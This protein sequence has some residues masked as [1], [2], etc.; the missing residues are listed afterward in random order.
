MDTRANGPSVRGA[1]INF[2]SLS[3]GGVRGKVRAN[4][5][6]NQLSFE[7]RHGHALDIK[8]NAI[9][10]VHQHHTTLIPGWL[11][12]V[13]AILIWIAWRGVTGK[14]Q[15]LLGAIGIVLLASHYIT[16]KPTLTIDTK[17]DDC[18]TVFGSDL[19]MMRLCSL[20]QNI[21]NGMTL[22]EARNYVDN[23]V[24]DSDYPRNRALEVIEFEPVPTELTASP[25]ITHF[26]ESM[27]STEENTV[28]DAEIIS[29]AEVI[30]DLDIDVWNE[31]EVG[32]EISPGLINRAKDNLFTQRNQVMQNGWQQSQ[33]QQPYNEIYRSGYNNP[34][35]NNQPPV[36]HQPQVNIPAP[37]P[38][39]SEFLPSFVG[40][41]TAH[42]PSASPEMFN[43]PD[44]PLEAPVLEDD[45]PSLVASVRKENN[46]EIIPAQEYVESQ[47]DRFPE[48]SRLT[49]SKTKRRLVT[50]P[51]RKRQLKARSVVGE[52]LGPALRKPGKLLRRRRNRTTD[53][54]RIQAEHA[55]SSQITESIENLARSN[56]G[57]VSDEEVSQML[58]HLPSRHE[59]PESFDQ[60]VSSD[61]DRGETV[62]SIPRI[63]ESS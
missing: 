21:Q 13:G 19:S 42:I 50:K 58:S 46:E 17:A 37:S 39:P 40:A 4:L 41:N 6:E 56:G 16:K 28:L 7:S 52:L 25:V 31:E 23:M 59:I 26:I 14:T 43:S 45:K 32:Q 53:A 9:T 44:S 36:Y 48:I 61:N 1:G 49:S 15:A 18:H 22:E 60:L 2:R 30:D 55:R 5:T 51:G 57:V 24:S 54:L 27:N 3:L 29:P 33:Q 12:G 35:Y 47:K 34:G 20:I 63:E 8:L 38:P 62:N 10:R 11:A